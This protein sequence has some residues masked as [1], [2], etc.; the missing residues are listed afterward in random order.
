MVEV[1]SLTTKGL[2]NV[3]DVGDVIRGASSITKE[4]RIAGRMNRR[5][6]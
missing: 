3:G 4:F 6:G 2:R 1:T 5:R